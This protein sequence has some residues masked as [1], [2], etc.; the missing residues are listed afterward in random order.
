MGLFLVHVWEEGLCL[1]YNVSAKGVSH[2][3]Q[4]FICLRTQRAPNAGARRAQSGGD[5]IDLI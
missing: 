4:S 1:L 2:L 5:S 3:S